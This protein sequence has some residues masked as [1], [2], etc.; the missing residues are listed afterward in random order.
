MKLKDGFNGERLLVLPQVIVK[1]METDPLMS[2]LHIT[3]IGYFPKAMHHF[4][5]RKEP[6]NQYVF[7][8]CVDGEGWFKVSHHSY[9]VSAGQ[10]FILPAGIPHTYGAD[11]DFPWTIYWIHFKGE[12]APYYAKDAVCPLD[13]RPNPHS[14]IED[15]IS[16]F[17]EMF[18]TLRGGYS[19]ENLHYVSSLFHYFL[20]SLCYI[21]QFRE[22]CGTNSGCPN[23]VEEA[24]HYMKENMERHVTLQ[25]MSDYIGYSVS[26][27]SML[28]K[29]S[30]GHSPLAY[31]N[32]LKIQHACLLLDT[33]DMQI[34]QVC[35]KVGIAD[36][37]YFSR[38]FSRIVGMSPTDYRKLKK[39]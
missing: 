31:F 3:D 30:T 17:E 9:T 10:Y 38:L 12:M 18:M 34:N 21:R 16:L 11:K 25:D 22:A 13:I 7:I 28:F 26:H 39:G 32:L 19:Q 4:R 1:A 36:L 35:H 27:F 2:K 5:E 6:I 24:V 33:T 20:G 37:F 29:K 23:A 14:R 8:Y 15:R